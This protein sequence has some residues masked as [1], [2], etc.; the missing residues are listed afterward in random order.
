MAGNSMSCSNSAFGDPLPGVYKY[1]YCQAGKAEYCNKDLVGGEA[2]TANSWMA[3]GIEYTNVMSAFNEGHISGSAAPANTISVET[4]TALWKNG[5]IPKRFSP[6]RGTGG[7]VHSLR[8]QRDETSDS[9]LQAKLDKEIHLA[10]GW[11]VTTSTFGDIFS[12]LRITIPEVDLTVL[13]TFPF[14][15]FEWYCG[16]DLQDC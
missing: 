14:P 6:S 13:K 12:K 11:K 9:E 8:V 10:S 2:W 7:D 16:K 4:V 15:P 5:K 3:L 1:C